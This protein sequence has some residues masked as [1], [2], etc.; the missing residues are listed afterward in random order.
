MT[1]VGDPRIIFLDEPT[2]GLDPRSRHTMWQIIRDLVASGVTILLTTQYLEEAD[3]L[4]DQIAVL[5]GGKLVAQGTPY[6]LKRRI[7]GVHMRLQFADVSGLESA[8]QILGDVTR[9]DDALTLQVPSDG[10]VRSIKALLDLLDDESIVVNDL[11]IHTPDLDD[12]F[13]A[14]TDHSN[15]QKGFVR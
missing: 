8:I 10:N 13:F 3:Q 9:D 11:S 2:T 12:V 4:A 5:D 15:T 7:G 14:L 1:L 6:E